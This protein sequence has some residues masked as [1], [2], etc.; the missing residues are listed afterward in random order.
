MIAVEVAAAQLRSGHQRRDLLLLGRLPADEGLDV[1]MVRC[2]PATILAARRVVP[3][4]LMAPAARSPILRKLIRPDER[5]PP[6]S[7]SPLAADVREVRPRSRAVLEQARLAHPQVHD[8]ALVDEV[9]AHALDE[10]GVRL[11]VLVGARRRSHLAAAMVDIVVALGRA[12]DAVGPV[13]AGVEPLRGVGRA[14]LPRQHQ[15]QLVVGPRAHRPRRRNSRP[16][17]PNRSRSRPGGRTPAWPMSRR[18]TVLP[19]AAPPGRP[20]R[21]RCATARPGRRPPRRA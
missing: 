7:R 3:P 8:A 19:R 18:S 9:V 20:R 11:G 5:P 2:R 21:R 1:G 14:H 6:D 17:S 10:A 16:S 12:V 4:D 13:E 15:A